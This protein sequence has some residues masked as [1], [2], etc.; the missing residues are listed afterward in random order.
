MKMPE[1]KRF[2]K[3][4]Q[5]LITAAT[6][7]IASAGIVVKVGAMHAETMLRLEV[8][9]DRVEKADAERVTHAELGLIRDTIDSMHAD[10]RAILHRRN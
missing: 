7:L 9:E 6:F 1:A 2:I 5:V 4:W 8:L 3:D 10:I